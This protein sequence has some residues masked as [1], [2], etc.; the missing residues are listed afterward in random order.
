M[1]YQSRTVGMNLFGFTPDYFDYSEAYF[2]EFLKA[3]IEN[4]K[5]EFFIPLMVN[6]L[7]GDGTAS[8]RVLRTTSEWFG[9][10]Y[11]EDKPQLMA[12]IERLISEGVYP[13]N[14]WA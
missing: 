9:V 1:V 13:R 12:N 4:L 8:M 7:I 3:N 6:K 11:K 5:S 10:T 14:L 2:R